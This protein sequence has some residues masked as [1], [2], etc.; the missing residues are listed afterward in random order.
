MTKRSESLYT[1]EEKKKKIEKESDNYAS[2]KSS[3]EVSKV[4]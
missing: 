4:I 3:A 2:I 1:A